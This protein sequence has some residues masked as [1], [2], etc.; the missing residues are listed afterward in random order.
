MSVYDL[1]VSLLSSRW[2][3]PFL[4]RQIA[5]AAVGILRRRRQRADRRAAKQPFPPF[6]ACPLYLLDGYHGGVLFW[7]WLALPGGG[8]WY[9]YNWPL[10]LQPAVERALQDSCFRVVLDLDAYTY[11]DMAQKAP[12]AI[13]QMRQAIRSGRLEVV[14]GTYAQPLAAS[15][16]GEAFLRQLAYGLAAVRRALGAEVGFFY[17][18]EP[19]YFPQLPQLLREFG[20]EGVMFRTQWAAFGTDPACD[21][22]VVRWRGPD[23]SVILAV[24]R[25]GFQRYDRLRASHPGLP[26]MALAAGEHPDWEPASLAPFARAAW[27]RGIA[28]PLVTDLKDT[29]LPDAPLPQAFRIAATPNVRFV[30][31]AEYFD[32]VKEQ[33]PLVEYG[34]DD[35]P[36]TLPWG[37]QGETLVRARV[38]AE[39]ALLLA[40][41]LDAVACLAGRGSEE[42]R[43]EEGWKNL[44]LAQHHD[45]HVCGP[46]HS[47]RHGQ[48]MA[49]VGMS[50]AD[51][52]RRVAEEVSRAAL[53][54]LADGLSGDVVVFNPSPWRRRDYVEIAVKGSAP[55]P[56]GVVFSDGQEEIPAQVVS[57]DGGTLMVGLVLDVPALGYRC[58]RRVTPRPSLQDGSFRNPWYEAKVHSDGTLIL[59]AKGQ[60]LVTAGSYLT[61]WQEG[62]WHDSRQGVHRVEQVED[63]PVYRRF[64]IAGELAGVPFCQ[65][66]TLY[67]RLARIDASLILDFGQSGVYLGPQMEDE[68]PGRAMAVQDERKLCLA[69]ASPLRQT[70][71]DSPFLFSQTRRESLVGLHWA[72]L[73]HASGVGVALL[74]LG[75]PGYHFDAQAGVL[76]NVLAWGPRW[77]MY[78]SDNSISRG[79]SRYT[80]LR[81]QQRYEYALLPYASRLE[82]Q[83]AAIDFRLPYKARWLRGSH[84]GPLECRAFVEVEPDQVM[85][86]ALFVSRGRLYL[87]LW[88]G[89]EGE[90]TARLRAGREVEVYQANLRLES[91]GR[92]LS[93]GVPLRAWGVQTVELRPA[94]GVED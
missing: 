25:Y 4:L 69:F 41:R 67:R 77:W 66:L 93:A 43:L 10:C 70:W 45:L 81:G 75:T 60:D 15:T 57:W 14:N 83:R 29:H 58:L 76:R 17:S 90:T 46:W 32:L 79:R 73:E 47:R 89:S 37:L 35:I 72:G 13:Q 40:E 26:N 6:P 87:R 2:V 85:A 28:Y 53:D 5:R 7:D 38:A 34:L 82:A 21:A 48:S 62:V 19:A 94:S 16:S 74:N 59:G 9:L 91:K 8:L 36:S 86:T 54:Y 24:P 44:C 39:G 49:E 65:T 78:A 27:V 1:A 50:Y 56:D 18:Q 68:E 63:G 51:S 12:R 31:L 88:N 92:P 23:G 22:S 80:A 64:L 30:T 71:C 33:G 52:A 42:G 55:D 61:V 11:E 3:P 84:G 20:F